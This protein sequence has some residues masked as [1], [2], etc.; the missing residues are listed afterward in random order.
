MKKLSD[1]SA[2]NPRKPRAD[3]ERNRL[4]LLEAAKTVFAEKGADAS[5]EEIARAAGV[6]IGTLYR[7]FP[8][9]DALVEQVY[10][11][12]S[13][14]LAQ[15]AADLA[16]THPPVEALRLWMRLFVD[17]LATKQI[18]SE[19]LNAMVCGPAEL[20]AESGPQLKGALADLAGRA[21]ASGAI[22]LE[23]DPL[24]MLRALVGVAQPEAGNAGRENAKR[25]VDM[26]IAGARVGAAD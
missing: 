17:Y 24:D 9:R 8:T 25:L 19:A 3:A 15:A 2:P 23:V 16:R 10:R 6:G 20:Y 5:L 14:Q 4:R 7:H 11:S 26:M 18:M 21:V 12:E 13:T 1:A 22:R